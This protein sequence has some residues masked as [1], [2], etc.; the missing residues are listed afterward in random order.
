MEEVNC[1]NI[2]ATLAGYRGH[3]F[4][5]AEFQKWHKRLMRKVIYNMPKWAQHNAH[6]KM[7]TYQPMINFLP[8][9]PNTTKLKLECQEPSK[10]YAKQ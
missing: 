1:K 7:A 2:Q 9:I 3:R 5:H 10:R 8:P 6:V 4:H